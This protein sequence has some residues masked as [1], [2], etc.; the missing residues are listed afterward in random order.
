MSFCEKCLW[1]IAVGLSEHTSADDTSDGYPMVV[2][3]AMGKF[4]KQDTIRTQ[5]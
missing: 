3:N 5:N 2:G 1:K 4:D